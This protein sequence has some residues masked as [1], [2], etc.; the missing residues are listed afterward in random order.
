MTIPRQ[1]F[2]KHGLKGGIVEPE[3]TYIAEKRFGKHV[4]ATTDTLVKVKALRWIDRRF[5]DNG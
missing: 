3:R 1:R 4:S 5:H 2:G